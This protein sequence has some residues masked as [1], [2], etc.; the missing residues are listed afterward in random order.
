MNMQYTYLF[1]AFFVLLATLSAVYVVI[2]SLRG[3]IRSKS[4]VSAVYSDGT[5]AIRGTLFGV[6]I[7]DTIASRAIGLSGRDALKEN[8]GMLFLFPIAA[9]YPFWMKDMLFPID[10]VWFHDEKIVWIKDNALPDDW[11][12]GISYAPPKS[13]NMVLEVIAGTVGRYGWAVGDEA[14]IR[15]NKN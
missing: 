6:E 9:K 4:E 3:D 12:S 11:R 15:M 2:P 13:A 8:Q 14:I 1:T 7:A 5:V 10:I